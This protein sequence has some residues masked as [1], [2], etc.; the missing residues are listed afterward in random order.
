MTRF[1]NIFGRA[2]ERVSLPEKER[3]TISF[4]CLLLPSRLP[5]FAADASLFVRTLVFERYQRSEKALVTA[6]ME[7]Y[8]QGVSTRKVKAV[9][10]ELCGH[11]FSSSSVSRIVGRLDGELEQ[12]GKRRL[13]DEYPY[14]VLDASYEKVREDVLWAARR[15]RSPSESIGKGAATFLRWR[16]QTGK[17]HRAGKIC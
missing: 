8:L 4:N 9:T 6:M 2:A 10:E 7:M 17:A 14:L 12:F 11:E 3:K 5:G 1:S 16:W 15:C 13:E